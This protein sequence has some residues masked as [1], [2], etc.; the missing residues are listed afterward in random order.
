MARHVVLAQ[1]R[2]TAAALGAVRALLSGDKGPAEGGTT[3]FEVVVDL[4]QARL[5][6]GIDLFAS[7][8]RRLLQASGIDERGGTS[9]RVVVLVDSVRP[10]SLDPIAEATTWDSLLAR[11]ILAL[12][13]L[14]WVFGIVEGGSGRG[15]GTADTAE[16]VK[17]F[18]EHDLRALLERPARTALLDP[19]GLRN[20]V[21]CRANRSLK[22]QD[23]LTGAYS[24]IPAF[25]LPVR[26]S[27]AAAIDE[28]VEFALLHGYAAYRFGLRADLVTSWR[29]MEG[30]FTERTG[31]SHGYTLLIE[32]VRLRFPD[33]PGDVHLSSLPSYLVDGRW[34]GREHHCPLLSNARDDSLWRILV[35]TG[36]SSPGEEIVQ[37]ND[38][39]LAQKPTGRGMTLF[40]PVGGVFDLWHDAG[41]LDELDERPC[42]GYVEG[43]SWPPESLDD[44]W[45]GRHAAPGQLTMIATHLL[46]RAAELRSRASTLADSIRAAVLAT[47]AVELLGGRTPA[48]TLSGL[49]L[50]HEMEV[51]AECAF[52]GAGFHFEV[53]RRLEAIEAEIS[54][55]AEWFEDDRR[56]HAA[57]DARAG[58]I[59]RLVLVY[60]EAG[61]AEEMDECL[62]ALRAVNRKMRRP[63]SWNPVAWLAHGVLAY[64]EWLMTSF[65]RILTAIGAWLVVFLLSARMLDCE[66][67]EGWIEAAGKAFTWF[68][69]GETADASPSSAVAVAILAIPIGILHIGILISFLYS[70]IARK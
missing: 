61:Q 7:V 64:G 46:E 63:K 27:R 36:Q 34:T 47:D 56:Q 30:L 60:R 37:T 70:L 49:A 39:Y 24:P 59:N 25:Q 35:T 9:E 67:R 10:D 51:R 5:D 22:A 8:A 6:G 14:H 40:K 23:G 50:K 28:E 57:L 48:L 16:R 69:G 18:G 62:A 42:K 17:V 45:A 43:F 38:E 11:L 13:E 26:S 65:S 4:E 21:R 20:F 52:V 19:T 15:D 3:G 1:S 55:V 31:S 44:D 66:G 68:F 33:K 32:D 58:V 12:P 2:V 29:L 53:G 41:L 54:A